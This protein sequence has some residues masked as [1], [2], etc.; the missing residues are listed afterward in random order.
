VARKKVSRGEC[1]G[2]VSSTSGVEVN[3]DVHKTP[4]TMAVEGSD[5][6]PHAQHRVFGILSV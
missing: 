5:A 4:Q 3:V 6:T 1:K 2:S